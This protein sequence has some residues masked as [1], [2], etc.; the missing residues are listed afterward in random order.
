MACIV[1]PRKTFHSFR[2]MFIDDLRDAGVQ[3]LL[4]KRM[5]GHEDSS[6]TF[7]IYGS[8]TPFKAM[9]EALGHLQ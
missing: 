2:Q 3:D 4:I 7:G 8:R 1:D 5:V 6:V 9:V